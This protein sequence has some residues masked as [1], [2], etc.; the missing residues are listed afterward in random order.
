MADLHPLQD[1]ST[2][3]G[4]LEIIYAF[5]KRDRQRRCSCGDA[6]LLREGLQVEA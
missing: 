2:V 3:Q 1:E 6:E 4:I 5:T